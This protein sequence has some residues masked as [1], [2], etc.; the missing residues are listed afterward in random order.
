[1]SSNGPPPVNP[2]LS[3]YESFQQRT[4]LVTR[5]MLTTL[6]LS[7]VLTFFVDPSF[8][9]SNI[10]LFTLFHGE[11]YRIFTS[12]L[13]CEGLLSLVFAFL[14]FT[15]S[16]TRVEHS[17]GST[18]FGTLVCTLGGL[19][20]VVFLTACC[21]LRAATGDESWLVC[22]SQGIWIVL[23]PII[24]IECA[25]APPDDQRKLFFCD[26]PTRF[27]PLG[28]LA[29]FSLMSGP[30]MS[31][32]IS[33]AVGYA[34]GFGRLDRLKLSTATYKRWEDG[35]LHNFTQREGW[36]VGHAATGSS[37]WLPTTSAAA[38]PYNDVASGWSPASF[39]RGSATAPGANAPEGGSTP[40]PPPKD[41]AAFPASG[42]QKIGSSSSSGSRSRPSAAEARV[43]R[44][45][46][47]EQV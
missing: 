23:F 22:S 14:S 30:S 13:V 42:G 26:V 24:A 5:Y 7:W 31:Y 38:S 1:M 40:G 20:N 16:G 11:L 28:L 43:A 2:V 36:V 19:T 37:A 12:P 21:A 35:C 3:A 10:P 29:V 4:P 9:A 41:R 17:M 18:A 32:A 44:L 45:A 25:H 47:L 6:A 39:L 15:D 46:K 27:Y 8:A 34:Y 33:V